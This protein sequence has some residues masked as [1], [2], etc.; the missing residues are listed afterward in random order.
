M[1]TSF[2]IFLLGTPGCGKSEIYRRIHERLVKEGLAEDVTRI[3]DFPKL[4]SCF[5]ADDQAE[6]RGEQRKYS[7]KTEDGGWLVTNPEVWDELLRRVD[8]DLREMRRERKVIFVEFARPDMVRS[9]RENFSEEILRSSFLLY[10]F[11]PFDICWERNV[12]R[13]EAALAA[14]TDD[15]L[16]SR[17]EM[18]STYAS[19][20]HSE[21]HRLGLP[22]LVVDNHLDGTE[23]LGY[24]IE[25]VMAMLRKLTEGD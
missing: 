4:H 10:I 2:Q 7:R 23:L 9:I 6:E 5:V 13:H 1:K 18:E 17:E 21:L 20:D 25:K 11:C 3:D 12:R 16:V 19:D 15:H 22:F 14:G 24:E 8:S